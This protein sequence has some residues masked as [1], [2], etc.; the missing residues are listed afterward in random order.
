[1]E[2]KGLRPPYPP[3][4]WRAAHHNGQTYSVMP[5]PCHPARK[6][7]CPRPGAS[8][9]KHAQTARVRARELLHLAILGAG[10]AGMW[11][12]APQWLDRMQLALG[13]Q[14]AFDAAAIAAPGTMLDRLRDMV[15]P[16]LVAG[17]G[18]AV[19]TGVAA[20]VGALGAGGWILSTRPIQPRFSR[21][22]PVAGLT[23]LFSRQ[24]MAHVLK[25]VLMTGVLGVVAWQFFSGSLAPVAVLGV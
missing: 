25:M 23:H 3:L 6:K 8:C 15:L 12:L 1:M 11:L 7:A 21:L 16:G 20:L 5:P 17:T 10:S 24:P 22:D 13:R 4:D 19:L 9:K 14:L 18:F 2:K